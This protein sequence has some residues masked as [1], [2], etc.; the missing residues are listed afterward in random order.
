MLAETF[1]DARI[2]VINTA[3]VAIN[4]HVVRSIAADCADWQ[5]D[6]FIVY[7]GNN[8]VVGPFGAGTVFQGA[9]ENLTLLRTGLWFRKFRA[10]QWVASLFAGSDTGGQRFTEWKGMEFFLDNRVSADDPRLTTVYASFA[11][12]L[13]AICDTATG[14]GAG[15]ILC[16]VGVNLKDSAPF[17]STP[18]A[19]RDDATAKGPWAE[20]Y[21]AGLAHLRKATRSPHW[22]PCNRRK[23]STISPPTCSS[24]WA[25]AAPPKGKP[26]P[27]ASTSP[28]PA[29]WT[30]CVFGR[31]RASTRPFATS[32][33]KPARE[34]SWSTS[35]GCW[36]PTRR[37][38]PAFLAT[39]CF[40]SIVTT[41]SR[42]NYALA[43]HVFPAV[44]SALP[45]RIREI[46]SGPC[47]SL[48]WIVAPPPGAHPLGRARDR[49]AGA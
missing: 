18:D 41:A 47:P 17:A 34:S 1:P 40:T 10:G 12:N 24:T 25:P 46:R 11:R 3:M 16:T 9:T 33:P 31:T 48:P 38:Q 35:P 37:A 42:G 30:N 32:R 14:A 27:L 20:A 5:P 45:K 6:L 23:R 4:S 15:T 8:E 36:K 44:V 39:I 13:S 29:T 21:Q 22:P 7:L 49:S 2:E 19:P 26:K 43:S 28:G